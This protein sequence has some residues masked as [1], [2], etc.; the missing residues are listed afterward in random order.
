MFAIAAMSRNRVV[1]NGNSIP[2][3]IPDEFKWFRRMTLGS[4]VIM[5]RRTFESL[6]KPLDGRINVVLTRH[7]GRLV[8]DRA[9]AERFAHAVVGPAAHAVRGVAQ[10]DLPRLPRTQVHLARGMDSLER[11]GVTERAWLC[12][13]VQLYEQFLAR[14]S[15][16]Y[17][18]VIDR[19]V[20][21]DAVFPPFEHLF[22]LAGV[23]AEF[24]EFRVLHYVR[25]DVAD[26]RVARSGR[27]RAQGRAPARPARRRSRPSS[28]PTRTTPGR[29]DQLELIR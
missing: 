7:P 5:G 12:G 22:D 3:R 4:V 18:S 14:C 20:E 23:V 28:T 27:R 10:L 21:G 13:G 25:N 2:W 16:L 6:P 1:G 26:V 19:E 11:A 15:D 17:L 29:D 24:P 8:A 9:L